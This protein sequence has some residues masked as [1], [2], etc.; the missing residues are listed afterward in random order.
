MNGAAAAGNLAV[1]KVCCAMYAHTHVNTRTSRTKAVLFCFVL[2]S[3]CLFRPFGSVFCV[4]HARDGSD[5]AGQEKYR[6][7]DAYKIPSP[8]EHPPGGDRILQL[9]H[10]HNGEGAITESGG[11]GKGSF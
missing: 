8:S 10:L 3:G 4:L 5:L 2:F 9:V 6:R 11:I 1:V 7:N